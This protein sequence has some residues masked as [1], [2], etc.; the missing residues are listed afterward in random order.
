MAA[1]EVTRVVH[2]CEQ[3]NEDGKLGERQ[4]LFVY[5]IFQSCTQS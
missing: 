1:E 3:A 4:A 2:R 5:F